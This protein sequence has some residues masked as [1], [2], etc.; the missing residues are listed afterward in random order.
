MLNSKKNEN[1]VEF[2]KKTSYKIF[3]PAVIATIL[4]I[5]FRLAVNI[6]TGE[7]P[8]DGMSGIPKGN[9][10]NMWYI[11]ML[12]GLYLLTPGILSVKNKLTHKQYVLCSLIMLVWAVISQAT[13]QQSLSY[14]IGVVIAFVSYFLLGDIIKEAISNGTLQNSKKNRVI[15]W[16]IIGVAVL[17]TFVWRKNGH[18]YYIAYAYTNFFSPTIALYSVSVF[19]LF[20]LSKVRKDCSRLAGKTYYIYIFHSVVLS[21]SARLISRISLS[22]VANIFLITIVTF[23]GAFILGE[24]FRLF[25]DK[26]EQHG[27]KTKWLNASLWSKLE[28]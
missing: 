26:L 8:W 3:L 15:C 13:S 19:T 25:F 16:L 28:R 27:M 6:L 22:E 4:L 10:Y 9:F 23:I 18:N 7:N 24:L 21:I 2:Y 5:A 11:W 20:G 12:A 17:V 14:S 1:A